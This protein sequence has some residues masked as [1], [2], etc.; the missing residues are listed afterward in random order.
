[1]EVNTNQ[2]KMRRMRALFFFFIIAVPVGIYLA[3]ATPVQWFGVA[4]ALVGGG[5]GV[6]CAF[7]ACPCCGE[8]SGV[9]FRSFYG[10]AFPFGKC[11]HCSTSYVK[12]RGCA[13]D[14]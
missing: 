13:G 6:V 4:L 12:A 14:S 5:A 3:V 11:I 10:G 1:M 9:F 2:K 7:T 8:L